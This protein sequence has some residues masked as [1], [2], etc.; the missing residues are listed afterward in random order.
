MEL[1]PHGPIPEAVAKLL[2]VAVA[3]LLM[4]FSATQHHVLSGAKLNMT[5]IH[6]QRTRSPF[7]PL[8]SC[9]PFAPLH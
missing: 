1:Q 3:E 9:T 8:C 7:G 6:K 4:D 2:A 5:I